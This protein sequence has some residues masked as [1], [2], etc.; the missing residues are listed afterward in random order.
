MEKSPESFLGVTQVKFY[1]KYC[2]LLFFLS[3]KQI[4]NSGIRTI[5]K[6]VSRNFPDLKKLSFGFEG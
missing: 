1:F 2:R 6:A 4:E 5:D 3:C